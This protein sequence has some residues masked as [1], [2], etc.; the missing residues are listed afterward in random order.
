MLSPDT[1]RKPRRL[2]P[3]A[4]IESARFRLAEVES[5]TDPAE[6]LAATFLLHAI[7][8]DILNQIPQPTPE[9]H[10]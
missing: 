5:A 10:E 4:L 1:P 7:V 3:V 6:A 9:S 2:I 8:K